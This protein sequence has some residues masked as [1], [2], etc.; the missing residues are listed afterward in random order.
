MLLPTL[1]VF[2]LI[3]MYLHLF[4]CLL[5]FLFICSFYWQ[6]FL[7]VFCCFVFPFFLYIFLLLPYMFFITASVLYVF[8][9]HVSFNMVLFF[10]IA[11]CFFLFLCVF[12]LVVSFYIVLVISY[13]KNQY[14][15]NGCEQIQVK[16]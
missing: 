6:N 8:H 15:N 7:Y 3:L 9:H 4:R 13:F 10:V 11:F 12:D 1:R 2:C 5:Q 16:L 14:I